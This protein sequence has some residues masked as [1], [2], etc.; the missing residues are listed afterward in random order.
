[1]SPFLAWVDFHARSRFA[2]ST[3]PEGKWGTTR[4]LF[5]LRQCKCLDWSHCLVVLL[6]SATHF[7]KSG[8]VHLITGCFSFSQCFRAAFS[9]LSPRPLPAPSPP[10][11]RKFQHGAFV[12]KLRAQRKRLHCRLE[13][14]KTLNAIT[15]AYT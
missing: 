13:C 4:S 6:L 7:R 11:F 9:L 12:S 2:R 15:T 8:H 14:S 3:I 10:L 5:F 1:M